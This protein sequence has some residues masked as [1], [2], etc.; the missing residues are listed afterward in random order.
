MLVVFGEM[1]E[2]ED[3]LL[4]CKRCKKKYPMNNFV[5]TNNKYS[6]TTCKYCRDDLRKEV[7][8]MKIQQSVQMR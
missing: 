4:E 3:K 8:R 2:V 7:E 5:N 6:T 1:R